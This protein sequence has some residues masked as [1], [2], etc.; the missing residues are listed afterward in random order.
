MGFQKLFSPSSSAWPCRAGGE[1]LL[2]A[3]VQTFTTRGRSVPNTTVH[4]WERER[5][6]DGKRLL[7][8]DKTTHLVLI[9]NHKISPQL[10]VGSP[11]LIKSSRLRLLRV[12]LAK[13]QVSQCVYTC[14]F[15]CM[16]IYIYICTHVHNVCVPCRICKDVCRCAH[17]PDLN[18][19]FCLL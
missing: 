9:I 8:S 11:G 4:H 7:R 16:R 15:I 19:W 2:G 13:Q 18:R 1:S 12:S 14:M 10:A 6:R 3:P 17:F 5:E